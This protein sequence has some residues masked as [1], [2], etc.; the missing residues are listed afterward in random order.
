MLL[1]LLAAREKWLAARR[2]AVDEILSLS[3]VARSGQG[4]PYELLF[5]PPL[6]SLARCRSQ[7]WAAVPA[8]DYSQATTTASSGVLAARAV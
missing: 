1:L 4:R 6:V 3:A 5:L 8:I 2:A 7:Q